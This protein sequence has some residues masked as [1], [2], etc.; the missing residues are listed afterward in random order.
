MGKKLIK[1]EFEPL[2]L[3]EDRKPTQDPTRLTQ[4][5]R[6]QLEKLPLGL[7]HKILQDLATKRQN[8][9]RK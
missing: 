5:E 9:K 2:F 6:K 3:L 1:I 7:R 4:K 8:R